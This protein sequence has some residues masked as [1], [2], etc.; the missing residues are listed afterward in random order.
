MQTQLVR[1]TENG[2]GTRENLK[3]FNVVAGQFKQ[4]FNAGSFRDRLADA[5]YPGA[6]IVETAEP[7]YY[8]IAESFADPAKAASA[9][10]ELK[11]KSPVPMKDPCPFL[12]D[13]TARGRQTGKAT[14]K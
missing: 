12:L 7:Y 9:L 13:A 5:G 2:G 10:K 4:L 11:A 14:K 1:I 3:Q 6:F 8:I